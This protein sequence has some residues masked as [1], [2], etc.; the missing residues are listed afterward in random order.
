ME[1]SRKFKMLVPNYGD[2]NLD[3]YISY[4]KFGKFEVLV[5][6]LW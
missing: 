5:L 1:S 2:Q 3:Q 6:K 4:G